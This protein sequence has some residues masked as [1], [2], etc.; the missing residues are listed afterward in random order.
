M[1]ASRRGGIVLPAAIA[2]VLGMTFCLWSYGTTILDGTSIDWLMISDRAQSFLGWHFYRAEPES[3]PL[4][5]I[6]SLLYPVGASLAYTDSFPWFSVALKPLAAILPPTFQIAGWWLVLSHGLLAGF[7]FLVLRTILD[8]WLVSLVASVLVVASPALARRGGHISLCAQ[9]L[10]LA[11]F[12]LVLVSRHDRRLWRFVL[13]WSVLLCFAAGTHPYLAAM[14]LVIALAACAN[15]TPLCEL[16]L[17]DASATPAARPWPAVVALRAVFVL[18]VTAAA[19]YSFGYVGATSTTA[20][21]FGEHS[22]NLLTLL[23]PDG[24]SRILPTLPSVPGQY[25]GTAFLGTGT[26]ALLV[27]AALA[28]IFAGARSSTAAAAR[29]R[30]RTRDLRLLTLALLAMALFALSSIIMLGTV[31]VA[32]ARRLYAHLEPLP[33]TFRASGRFIWPLH[34][35]LILCAIVWLATSLRRRGATIAIL[36]AALA[37]QLWDQGELYAGNDA[38]AQAAATH[39][40]ALRSPLW[41]VAGDDYREIRLVPPYLHDAEC[42]QSSY[43]AFFYVPFAYAAGLQGMRINSG[44][45]SRQPEEQLAALCRDSAAEVASGRVD[46]DVIYVVSDDALPGFAAAKRGVAR[47]GLLDGFNVCVSAQ[48]ATPFATMLPAGPG[49]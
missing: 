35:A 28:R 41:D 26:L 40:R 11:A 37:L 39:W 32:S 13:P 15:G 29:I 31:Q 4:G 9:W 36:L 8:D 33:S 12:Y 16:R 22:A 38:R 5:R 43:P 6:R 45:L 21:G 10:I 1:L 24:G 19:L 49:A 7:A 2:V 34:Y 46:P 47:C 23:D 25:E 44:H 42:P 14:T 20:G 3:F 17:H 18:L 48:R 30:V 27:V